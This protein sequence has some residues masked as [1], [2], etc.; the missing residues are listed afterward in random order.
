MSV[1][2]ATATVQIG[3][4]D[5]RTYLKE[6]ATVKETC[7][8]SAACVWRWNPSWCLR[9][10]GNVLD[11]Q[12]CGGDG[13]PAGNCSCDI[14]FLVVLDGPWPPVAYAGELME[15]VSRQIGKIGG[16]S[17]KRKS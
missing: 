5:V 14:P 9:C 15:V 2:S 6:T 10:N 13:I 1:E 11:E 16:L 7:L 3:T 4:V 8:M 12:M 17:L